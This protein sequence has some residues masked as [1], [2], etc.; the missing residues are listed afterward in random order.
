[1]K[2]LFCAFVT[3]AALIAFPTWAND[4]QP[5]IKI[6]DIGVY[7]GD[8]RRL[9]PYRD[10]WE[11]ARDE[12]N[13]SGGVL[14]R[15]LEIISRDDQGDP[16]AALRIAE[17]LLNRDHV[18]IL[19]GFSLANIELALSDF[20]Q[21]NKVIF[22]S[23]NFNSDKLIWQDGN[24]YSFSIAA[25]AMYAF[26]GMFVERAALS[27]AKTWEAINSN[28]EWGQA[29]QAAFEQNLQKYAP[30]A[31]WV[32]K[33]WPPL[34]GYDMS[35]IVQ[36]MLHSKADAIYTSLWG[37][38]L[39]AFVREGQKVGLFKNKT[40]VSYEIAA[41][42]SFELFKNETPQGWISLGYPFADLKDSEIQKFRKK[43]IALY[44][45]EPRDSSF[46]GYVG[47]HILADA[48]KA[49]GSDDPE[50][51]A[52]LLPGFKTETLLGPQ[53]IRAI[54][55]KTTMGLWIGETALVDGKPEFVKFDYK[56]G[57]DFMP[58][59]DWIKAQR[60]EK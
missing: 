21:K 12:I 38:H 23:S 60:N 14:G 43:Y 50:K 13:A 2:K 53:Q 42:Q 7:T 36:A 22:V 25:P 30:D 24:R 32:D 56:S 28:Y 19:M 16:A 9:Y 44:K 48:I 11:M 3:L 46:L 6:G 55:H 5:P 45:Q 51:L 33:Q 34:K 57:S 47:L 59:D 40:V 18:S 37:P 29:N 49:A 1:M 54:D 26:N 10:G 15:P 31:V 8:P 41:P 58:S 4:S 20:A 17:D 27:G 39:A 35:S 52:D